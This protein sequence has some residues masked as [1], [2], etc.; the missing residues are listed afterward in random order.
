MTVLDS[1]MEEKRVWNGEKDETA[2]RAP[3]YF[4]KMLAVCP[5]PLFTEIKMEMYIE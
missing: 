3:F 4:F 2:R 5:L 1:V